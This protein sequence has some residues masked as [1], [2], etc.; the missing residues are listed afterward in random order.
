MG[1]GGLLCATH[2]VICRGR[3]LTKLNLGCKIF[4]DKVPVK[5]NMDPA[6]ILISESQERM[7]IVATVKHIPAI[8]NIFKTWDLEYS[9]IGQVTDSGKYSVYYDTLIYNEPMD[10]FKHINQDWKLSLEKTIQEIPLKIKQPWTQ[11]DFTVGNRTLKGPDQPGHYSILNIYENDKLL[12]L[13]WAEDFDTCYQQQLT[14]NATPLCIVNCLNFGHPQ[15][16]MHDLA[17]VVSTLTKKCKQFNI[18]V[19]G[20]NVSLYNSVG[21]KSIRPTPVLVMLGIK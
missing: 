16:S 21:D 2:E 13:T 18:P 1:A 9:I 19:V 17:E 14:L 6:D 4:L 7:L 15:Y 20:G 10:S 5:C 12:I 8:F 11:Y 3:T